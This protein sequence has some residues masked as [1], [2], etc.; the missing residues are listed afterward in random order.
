MDSPESELERVYAFMGVSFG[1]AEQEA[2]FQHTHKAP[3]KGNK[4]YSTFR[5]ENFT[6]D[7][8]KTAL[9]GEVKAVCLHWPLID[10]VS[11]S[12]AARAAIEVDRVWLCL[13][14]EPIE[15]PDLFG[16]NNND[17]EGATG[18][19]CSRRRDLNTQS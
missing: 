7:A 1:P 2:A 16:N 6:H 10:F 3:P 5:G 12:R 19:G 8:W 17:D 13:H 14:H 11:S 9:T 4:Y 18:T 15:L